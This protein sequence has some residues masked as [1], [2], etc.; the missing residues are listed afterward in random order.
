MF[1]AALDCY[2][3]ELDNIK[4]P[5]TYWIIN[6]WSREFEPDLHGDSTLSP[7]LHEAIM[8]MIFLCGKAELDGNER[9]AS[10]LL[11]SENFCLQFKWRS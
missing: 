4:A 10:T 8:H 3:P 2:I 1:F 5:L 11:L 9:G 6:F 7:L